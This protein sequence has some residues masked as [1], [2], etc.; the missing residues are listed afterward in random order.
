MSNELSARILLSAEDIEKAIESL[1][2]QIIARR[3]SSSRLALVGLLSRGHFIAR[4]V[5]ERLEAQGIEILYGHLDISLYRDDFTLG[6]TPSLRSSDLP[7]TVDEADII[8]FDDVLYTGRT[9]RAALNAVMDYGR[10]SRV[11]LAVLVDRGGREM[12]IQADYV[13]IDMKRIVEARRAHGE[14]M[15]DSPKIKVMLTEENNE[16][17]VLMIQEDL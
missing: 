1:A 10:P 15:P 3:C 12:P 4:R 8:L 11:E 17:A 6:K 2:Q 9:I 13:G 14:D 5:G 7:F 16:D